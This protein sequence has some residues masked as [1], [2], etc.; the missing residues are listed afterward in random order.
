MELHLRTL[1]IRLH[2]LLY[3]S[4]PMLSNVVE[5][6][7][8]LYNVKVLQFKIDTELLE[9]ADLTH[10]TNSSPLCVTKILDITPF[11]RVCSS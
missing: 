11:I 10:H 5:F 9:I 1:I 3:F 7:C 8:H 6:L 2:V 4:C